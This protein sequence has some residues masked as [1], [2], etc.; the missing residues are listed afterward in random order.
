MY[1]DAT[2][3]RSYFCTEIIAPTISP[4]GGTS[5]PSRSTNH[6]RSNCRNSVRVFSSP[7]RMSCSDTSSTATSRE[8]YLRIT[9]SLTIS[10]SAS[11]WAGQNE[12]VIPFDFFHQDIINLFS[13]Q[14]RKNRYYPDMDRKF[15]SS[16]SPKPWINSPISSFIF[17]RCLPKSSGLR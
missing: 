12:K 8:G 5:I 6:P 16:R 4:T 2:N 3:G 7:G 15:Y 13:L 17:T 1:K 9:G 10:T 14:S 11:C